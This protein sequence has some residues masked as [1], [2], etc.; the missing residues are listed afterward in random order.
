VIKLHNSDKFAYSG[1]GE[2]IPIKLNSQGHPIIRGEMTPI[3]GDPIK[4]EF[5][6]DIG[7]GG[8]LALYSPFVAE[9]HLPGPDVSTI[10]GHGIGGAGGEASGRFGRVSEFRIG[11]YKLS[12]PITFFSDD[13]AGA[14]ASSDVQG[15]I[16]EEILSRFKLLFDYT[17]DRIILE[18]TATFAEAVDRAFSG[19]SVEGEGKDYKT[20][21]ITKVLENS[22][23]SE[24]GSQTDD[25]ITA[26][27]ERG[28]SEVTLSKLLEMFKLRASY[29][30]TVRR[31]EQTMKVTLTPRALV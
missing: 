31:G 2:S 8:G 19:L 11:K 25:V 13:K 3:G 7:A 16:G 27:D 22:P 21:R 30:V 15:N 26:V 14:F 29:K 12:K 28:S 9:H 24:T 18:P 20:F 23:A 4:G 6:L 17:N 5:A 1:P 10:Q